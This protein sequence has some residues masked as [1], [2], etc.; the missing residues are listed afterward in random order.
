MTAEKLNSLFQC[1]GKKSRDF[2][3]WALSVCGVRFSE[4]EVS[5]HRNGGQGITKSFAALYSIY[6]R[7]IEEGERAA[8]VNPLK[9]LQ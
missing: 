2:I 7:I 9:N 1:S 4:S 6:F 8:D 5:R 3:A